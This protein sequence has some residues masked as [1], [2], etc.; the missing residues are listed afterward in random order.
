MAERARHLAPLACVALLALGL[1][2]SEL[3]LRTRE[4]GLTRALT[5]AQAEAEGLRQA[6][7]QQSALAASLERRRAELARLEQQVAALEVSDQR[8]A[9][10][11]LVL[12]T[13]A[14]TLP[15]EVS[16]EGLQDDAQTLRLT[17]FSLDSAAVQRL[18]RDLGQALEEV[19]LQPLPARVRA[20][21]REGVPGYQFV[22][23]LR[24]TQTSRPKAKGS[25]RQVGAQ[26]AGQRP[27]RVS[28]GQVAGGSQ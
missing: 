16:L 6:R 23:E 4:A 24:R 9:G 5:R 19:G 2:V 17:G 8:S 22:L 13:L 26:I 10:L 18:S 14:T 1:G 12:A 20:T 7:S 3:V 27:L 25:T 28:Q 11:A 15:D 21:L